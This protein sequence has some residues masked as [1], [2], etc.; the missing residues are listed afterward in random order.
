M[1]FTE[2]APRTRGHCKTS[3]CC[4]LFFTAGCLFVVFIR[5]LPGSCRDRRARDKTWAK[6]TR[7]N[8]HMYVCMSVWKNESRYI[9]NYGSME[10]G[11]MD[12]CNFEN[13]CMKTLNYGYGSMEK[14]ER[15]C[16]F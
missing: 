2:A 6:K 4:L 10:Y 5:R 1:L 16:K 12:E 13:W 3:C 11:I 7:Y 8:V 9:L 14:M 15:V